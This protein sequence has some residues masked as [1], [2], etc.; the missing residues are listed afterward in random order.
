MGTSGPGEKTKGK[1]L[2]VYR[3]V[4]MHANAGEGTWR[5]WG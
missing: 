2:Y 5:G 1:G 4:T 3:P